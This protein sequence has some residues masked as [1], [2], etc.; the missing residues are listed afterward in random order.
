MEIGLEI[1]AQKLAALGLLTQTPQSASLA[2][3]TGKQLELNNL[4]ATP[5]YGG[6]NSAIAHKA[7]KTVVLA[8][9]RHKSNN[10]ARRQRK[11]PC[12]CSGWATCLKQHYYSAFF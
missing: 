10:Y 12:L 3:S 4:K 9:A 2:T 6:G 1:E 8:G 5:Q 7:R 11:L